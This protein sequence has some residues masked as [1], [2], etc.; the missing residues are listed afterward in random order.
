MRLREPWVDDERELVAELR[1]D[2]FRGLASANQMAGD[3]E[4]DAA[5]HERATEVARLGAADLVELDLRPS[6][7]A[8]RFAV[9]VGLAVADEKERHGEPGLTRFA[10]R[11]GI[12]G[13]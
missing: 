6:L 3:D 9:P 2:E 8:R 5:L 12:S 10:C 7:A 11:W 1:V 4:P 13:T